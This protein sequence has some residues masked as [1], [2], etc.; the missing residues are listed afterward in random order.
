MAR[1]GVTREQVYETADNLTRDG[2]SPTVVAVRTRLGGG[3]PNNITKWLAEWRERHETG[4]PEAIL[5][6]P[7]AVEGIMRQV[8]VAACK[9]AEGA[10]SAER[11]ALT[12]AREAIEQ[13][14]EQMFA[15]IE[16]LD[17]DLDVARDEGQAARGALAEE[18][19]AHDETRAE[20]REVRAIA[21]ER[22]RHLESQEAELRELRR[23]R[24]ESIA[25][26]STLE[27]DLRHAEERREEAVAEL[28]EARAERQQVTSELADAL[29]AGGPR[30]G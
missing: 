26:V 5:P 29:K 20:V 10:L 3:S 25:R 2:Q 21:A 4:K 12:A 9:A 7:D 8:W 11:E 24:E 15:E 17:H 30:G 14:R 19:T 16:R 23:Q 6:V 28:R 22:D 27:A 13:E 18:R 1:P